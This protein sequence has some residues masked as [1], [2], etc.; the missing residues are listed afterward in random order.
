MMGQWT[1][2]IDESERLHLPTS[3]RAG[4]T[5]VVRKSDYD[6]LKEWFNKGASDYV[7]LRKERDAL[8][9]E[10]EKLKGVK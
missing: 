8:K 4:N 6:T 9:A 7:A 5:V 2:Y 10:I 1:V 3:F